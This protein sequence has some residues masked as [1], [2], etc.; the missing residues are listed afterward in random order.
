MIKKVNCILLVDDNVADNDFHKIIIEEVGAAELVRVAENGIEALD[1]LLN[2]GKFSNVADNPIP[3]LIF[4]DINMP[5]MNGFEFMESYE[6]LDEDHK[7][8]FV[9]VMLTTSINPED[10]EKAKKFSDLQGFLNKPLNEDSLLQV[11]EE[12]FGQENNPIN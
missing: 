8:K 2:K 5:R 4:L 9:V 11:L 12:Y 7:A 10:E 6:K 3:D 1:Y